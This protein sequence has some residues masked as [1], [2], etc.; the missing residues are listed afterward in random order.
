MMGTP[1]SWF[2]VT[3]LVSRMREDGLQLDRDVFHAMLEAL[4]TVPVDAIKVASRIDEVM[5]EWQATNDFA[6]RD[7]HTHNILLRVLMRT[8]RTLDWAPNAA[9]QR[10]LL[11]DMM[12]SEDPQ[13]RA[14]ADT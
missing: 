12:A 6:G 5:A 10:R 3:G 11:N 14:N 13:Q 2:M 9:L 4:V 1:S 7:V 8:E